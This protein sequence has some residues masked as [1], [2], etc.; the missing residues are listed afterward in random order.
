MRQV[1]RVVL[2]CLLTTAA[3]FAGTA[4]AATASSSA[5]V[6]VG[7]QT[8]QS[9]HRSPYPGSADAFA[10]TAGANW[11]RIVDQRLPGR[12]ESRDHAVDRT[13]FRRRW[14]SRVAARV[15]LDELAGRRAWNTVPIAQTTVSAQS[16]YWIAVLGTGGTLYF[17]QDTGGSC[18][19]ESSGST[20]LRSLPSSWRTGASGI[21]CPISAYASGPP[22]AAAPAA[23]PGRLRGRDAFRPDRGIQ[24]LAIGSGYRTDRALRCVR[25]LVRRDALHLLLVG[26]APIGRHL[27]ARLGNRTR[28]HLSGGR[29]EVRDAD[30]H[31]F[32]GENLER[33]AQRRCEHPPDSDAPPHPP[34]RSTPRPRRSAEPPNKANS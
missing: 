23:A 22:P 4:F 12:S 2:A 17:R 34:R 27:S 20:R 29:D 21:G 7:D 8:V 10:L 9:S 19:S 30:R 6:L 14:P 24:L 18:Q 1:R 15:G 16:N 11:D 5:A 13:V 33:R 3:G 25:N 28:L 26:S 32:G 31:R